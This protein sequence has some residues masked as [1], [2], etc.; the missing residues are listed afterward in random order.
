MKNIKLIIKY[1][2][3]DYIRNSPSKLSTINTPIS[4]IYINIP[5]EG[6]VGS[7]LN[8]CLE[9]NFDVLNAASGNRCVDSNVI[10]LV[11]LGPIALF[12]III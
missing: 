1:L 4:Q 3:C 10:R 7:L 6:S 2:K 5:G 12:K 9:L 8:S 11:N